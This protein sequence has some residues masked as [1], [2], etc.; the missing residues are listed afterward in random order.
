VA[1]RTV[2]GCLCITYIPAFFTPERLTVHDMVAGT[3]VVE[4]S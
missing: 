2:L 3:R 1:I 4:T